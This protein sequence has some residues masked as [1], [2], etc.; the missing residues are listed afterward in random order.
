MA[1][2]S[3]GGSLSCTCCFSSHSFCLFPEVPRR[4][5]LEI[6]SSC[7]ASRCLRRH[8]CAGASFAP[9]E[10]ESSFTVVQGTLSGQQPPRWQ[11]QYHGPRQHREGRPADNARPPPRRGH[12]G[13]A[14]NQGEVPWQHEESRR[15]WCLLLT[16]LP[17]QP[18]CFPQ[19]VGCDRIP[20]CVVH[21]AVPAPSNP[22]MM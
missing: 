12:G 9:R 8:D 7:C 19:P 1:G 3:G 22:L 15:A 14:G 20:V 17:K 10:E 2:Q 5:P 21:F 13:H 4:S 16:S 11:P 6:V 18:C